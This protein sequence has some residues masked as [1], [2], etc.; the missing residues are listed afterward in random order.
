MNRCYTKLNIAS[1]LV[2]LFF[3]CT[4]AFAQGTISGKVT[5]TNG[6]AII[7]ANV[8]LTG[9]S[10][11]AATDL[12]GNYTIE[13]VPEGDYTVKASAVGYKA[14]ESSVTVVDGLIATLNF[15]LEEDILNLSEVVVTGTQNPKTKL[16]SSVAIT[17]LDAKGIEKKAPRNTADLLKAVPGFYME[18]SGGEGGNNLF[19]R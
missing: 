5:D 9:T 16:E 12:N 7:G 4:V 1:F 2:I 13:N 15:T 14:E 17:T 11:G 8:F 6:D 18:S 3:S 10:M 19:S